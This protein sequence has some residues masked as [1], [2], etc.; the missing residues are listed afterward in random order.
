[1]LDPRTL[2]E[3]ISSEGINAFRKNEKQKVIERIEALGDL[4]IK[5]LDR[6][7]EEFVINFLNSLQDLQDNLI[8]GDW[9]VLNR[10]SSDNVL[11]VTT[12]A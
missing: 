6:S 7:E 1:L 9:S 4:A 12:Q 11:F 3:L 5:A 8:S 10:D 2:A